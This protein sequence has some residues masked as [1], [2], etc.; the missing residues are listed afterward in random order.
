MLKFYRA[1]E[2]GLDLARLAQSRIRAGALGFRGAKVGRKVNIGKRCKIERP[3]CITLGERSLIEDSVYF[4]VVDD[5]ATLEFGAYAFVGRGSEFDVHEKIVVGDHALIAP[6]C[7]ITDHGHSI[8]RQL[9]IDEQETV[10]SPVVIGKDVWLGANVT[11]VAG[12]NIGDG[13][14]VGAN[15]VVTRDVPAMAVVAGVPAQILRYRSGS[16]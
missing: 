11:V 14:V 8:L 5:A 6:G 15:A 16:R 10:A 2:K 7:F 12:V 3:W 13:A 1:L 9:R 4:K